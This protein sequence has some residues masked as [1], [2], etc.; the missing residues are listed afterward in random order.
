M[1][2]LICGLTVA[3]LTATLFIGNVFAGGKKDTA[4][5]ETEVKT[6]NTESAEKTAQ[7]S[8]SKN[9]SKTL[10]VAS[11]NGPTSIPVAYFYENKPEI[12]GVDINFEI[13][14]SA[15]VELPKLLKGEVD[16]GFLPPNVAAK[17][18][19][20]GNGALICLGVSGNGNIFLV[21]PDAE[22]T[23]LENLKGKTV[24]V[25]GSGAT[26]EYMFRYL[27]KS[28]NIETGAEEDKV[29]LDF[30]IPAG[31][32]AT[33]LIS[34]KIRYAVVP[35]PFASVAVMKG[36]GVKKAIDFQ[37]E[38][39]LCNSENKTY[40]IT[41]MVARADYVKENPETVK[42]FIKKY[43]EATGWTNANPAKSG[44]IVQKSTLGLMAPIVAK[45]IPSAAFVWIDAKDARLS[46]EAVL[47]IFNE[48]APESIGGK[49]PSDDFYF[50]NE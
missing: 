1:K 13:C 31:E 48:F 8:K 22:I 25:A 34:E 42:E 50:V 21:T 27:L 14:A 33:A 5:S 12:K 18:F 4:E 23:S 2:K 28:N 49:L 46:I 20:S 36:D 35:E 38:F 10:N 29:N 11:L 16:I 24:Y 19:N 41:V 30:S 47:N 39:A 40:P 43:N 45:S 37:K 15:N 32:L 6:E 26:P 9:S 44:V 17:V 7:S 3:A